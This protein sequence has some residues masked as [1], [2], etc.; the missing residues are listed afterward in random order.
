MTAPSSPLLPTSPTSALTAAG[1][2]GGHHRR[3]SS[4]ILAS[5]IN[6]ATSVFVSGSPKLGHAAVFDE[7]AK[8]G[9][10]SGSGGGHMKDLKRVELKI[11]GMTVCPLIYSP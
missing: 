3:Q 1:R 6:T 9:D 8:V 7:E 5:I 4:S 10:G 11:G 2:Q